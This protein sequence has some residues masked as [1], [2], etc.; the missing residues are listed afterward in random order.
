MNQAAIQNTLSIDSVKISVDVFITVWGC[1]PVSPGRVGG[2]E[3]RPHT[4]CSSGW[5]ECTLGKSTEVTLG[6]CNRISHVGLFIL[7][8]TFHKYHYLHLLII[9]IVISI[10][11]KMAKY[12]FFYQIIVRVIQH[13][14]QGK[15][16]S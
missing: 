3:H 4:T 15:G 14:C 16:Y 1:R 11:I 5:M 2:V 6:R 7:S 13:Y 8:L 9:I 12:L 10:I